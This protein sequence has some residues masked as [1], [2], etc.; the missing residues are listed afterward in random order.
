MFR[1]HRFSDEC[2]ETKKAVQKGFCE[3]N[4][5]RC[6]S[7]SGGLKLIKGVFPF[8]F[9]CVIMTSSSG[10]GK[11]HKITGIEENMT[12][13]KKPE[14]LRNLAAY[15]IIME[16]NLPDIHADGIFLRHKKSGARVL[17]L[18]CEDNNK[19]FNIA[20]RTPPENSTGVAHI[21]EHTVLCG[22]EKFPLKDPFV[23]LAKGSMNTFLNAMTF[24][25]KTMF[26]VASTND[27]DFKNLVD[28]YLDAVFHPNIYKEKNLFRQEGWNFQLENEADELTLNGVVYNEMKGVFSSPDDI[29]ERQTF[30]ALFPDTPYGVESGGDPDVIPELTYEAFLDF[31]RKYYHPSNSYIYLY[32]NMD[33]AEMLQWMDENYLSEYVTA[34]VESEIPLQK[35]FESMKVFEASYPIADQDE[36]KDNTY[37]SYSVVMGSPFDDKEAAAADVL[38]YALFSA[39]GAPVKEALVKAGI[40]KDIYGTYNDGILQPY[41][42][43]TAKGANPEDRER[44][45]EVLHQEFETQL[46][47]GIDRRALLAGLN[48]QEF[49]YREADFATYPKGLIYGIDVFDTWLYDDK[50]P[51]D[52]F[53]KLKTYQ[54]LREEILKERKEG[55]KGYFEK[56]LE[57]YFLKNT[58]SAYVILKPEKGLNRKKEKALK[59]KLASLKDEMS[60]DEI[61]NLVRETRQLR[62]FQETPDKSENLKLLPM[63]K[64]TDLNRMVKSYSN[65]TRT[66]GD[67][68]AVCH[69]T[70]TN[71]IAYISLLFDA[72]EIG[73]ESLPFLGLLKTVL[74]RL[75]TE[76][77]SY[78]EL[79]NEI[80]I[81]TGGIS[82]GLTVYRD[83]EDKEGYRAYLG[84][85][86]KAVYD[87]LPKGLQLVREILL[88]S[89]FS[90]EER[91]KHLLQETMMQL[92]TS[93]IQS[94]HAAAG[95]RAAA[96]Y[97]SEAAFRDLTGGIGYYKAVKSISHDFEKRPEILGRRLQT[98]MD[99][100][101][102]RSNLIIS[103]TAEKDGFKDFEEAAEKILSVLPRGSRFEKRQKAEPYGNLKEGFITA[104]QV[105]FVAQSGPF[106][107]AEHDYN[108]HL[109][110]LRQILN[111]E[112]L[113][114][115][116]RVTGGAYGCGAN[117]SRTGEMTLR[118]FRDPNLKRSLEVF[119]K[120]ESYLENFEADDEEMTKYVIGAVSTVDTPLTASLYDSV[121]MQAYMNGITLEMRQKNRD[122]LLDTTAEDIRMLLP[123]IKN[124]LKPDCICVV[125]SE[126]VVERDKAAFL[127]TE[128]LI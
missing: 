48:C 108:G 85:R 106:A 94:G 111:Y 7:V 27:K 28:V 102:S 63:L 22:S 117:F 80:G 123:Y 104:G 8:L 52:A 79:D 46:R 112:Y 39:S 107:D 47:Q 15:D 32:G 97:L 36:E 62:L 65:T 20:F 45:L 5:N 9:F 38:D 18:P 30:N 88:T 26:P 51:F 23:E 83:P 55:E 24:P 35:P 59:E 17:L 34:S 105:Q 122:E 76:H 77:Y 113:W 99:T 67:V 44:F 109:L 84:I 82:S 3:W 13:S 110:V 33:M 100:L 49:S 14:T 70:Q 115:N 25:D 66:L 78:Q 50:R 95:T 37:L 43:I 92:Q 101:I 81:E 60:Q 93:L 2:S 74:G 90:D 56:L 64:R 125:G 103:C 126:S 11:G 21:I 118:T 98:L 57:K 19:V 29:L 91:L 120:L 4:L 61:G 119:K 31:H 42:S 116:I 1:E 69:E 12:V 16:E 96:Y 71:G 40:G 124:A 121:C 86:V 73:E 53:K 87:K 89:D 6:V 114:Q 68:T 54:E 58:F 127:K 41:Y 75:S 128:N 10:A 72:G